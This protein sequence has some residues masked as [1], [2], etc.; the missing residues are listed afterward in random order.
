VPISTSSADRTVG[1]AVP[2]PH[3][4]GSACLPCERRGRPDRIAATHPGVQ[5]PNSD[6]RGVLWVAASFVICPCHLPVTLWAVAALLAG[7][8]AGSL[9]HAHQVLT[10][11]GISLLWAAGTWHGMRL[12]RRSESNPVPGASS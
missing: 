7:T 3:L 12:M 10:G 6:L 1:I 8:T 11:I 4:D 2:E 9:V 5:A